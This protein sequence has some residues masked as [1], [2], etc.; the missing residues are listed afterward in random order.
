MTSLTKAHPIPRALPRENTAKEEGTAWSPEFHDRVVSFF[1]SVVFHSSVLLALAMFVYQHAGST[2][3]IDVIDAKFE[4][5]PEPK[6]II[7][8]DVSVVEQMSAD[9]RT[10]TS[11]AVKDVRELANTSDPPP[12]TVA[13]VSPKGLIPAAMPRDGNGF[14]GDA[15][16]GAG[17]NVGALITPG[18]GSEEEEGE[19]GEGEVGFFGTK[20][21]GKSFVFIV[22]C[23]GSMRLPTT[24]PQ[25]RQPLVTR[26]LR[27]RTELLA[28]LGQLSEDQTF[29]VFFYNHGTYPMFFPT[30]AEGLTPATTEN[31]D[32]A[33]TWI[34]TVVP[35]GETDPR[36]AF[37]LALALRPDVIFFLTDGIIPP[38]TRKVAKVN[39][40][41]RTRIHTIAI[42][43]P[44]G[45]D[46]LKG[47]AQDNQGR[48]RF[49]P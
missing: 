36:E 1:V 2:E 31:L 21:K 8:P 46:I 39:N 26:F 28:S 20:A 15:L 38:V 11:Q 47:I 40:K 34:E 16:E 13:F 14:G 48:F 32:L 29:Y 17:E 24:I 44:G 12:L 22:D 6:P 4:P 37:R 18:D 19:T 45:Q 23:S 30:P 33:R 25:P 42:A 3:L 27:A 10:D 9:D 43:I 7:L 41:S 35:F 49:V 5:L